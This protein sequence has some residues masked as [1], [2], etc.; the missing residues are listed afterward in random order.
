MSRNI[1]KWGENM[2]RP[3]MLVKQ[4]TYRQAIW[5]LRGNQFF[6]KPQ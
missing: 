3:Q 4:T 5:K 6:K 1:E 2:V